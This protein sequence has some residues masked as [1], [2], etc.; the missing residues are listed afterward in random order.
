MTA[1]G[2][3]GRLGVLAGGLILAGVGVVFLVVGL[4]KADKIASSAGLFVGLAGLGV[5]VY[6]VIL[7]RRAS[8]PPIPP[9]P[10][11]SKPSTGP[12]APEAPALGE[13]SVAVAGENSGP[14]VT[15]DN[16]E[17]S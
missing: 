16:N 6:G 11:S 7:A 4:D 17:V 2:W 12:P 10:L 14:I 1:S 15:G 5:S 9:T 13:R 8:T 3:A